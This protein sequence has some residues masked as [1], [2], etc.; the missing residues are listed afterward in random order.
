MEENT[1]WTGDVDTI[2]YDSSGEE[3]KIAA[4]I[5]TFRF[6][7]SSTDE[8]KSTVDTYAEVKYYATGILPENPGTIV[9]TKPSFFKAN[10]GV[11]FVDSN[12][13]NPVRPN[14][15]AQTF[16]VENYDGGVFTTGIDLYFNKKSNIIPVKVYLTNVDFD[17]PGKNIIPGTEK[18][19]SPFTFLK[20]FTNGNVNV[21]QGESITGSTSAASGPLAKIMDK[22]GVDLVPSSSGRYLLTNEQVYTM[23]LDNHNGRSFNQNECGKSKI[24]FEKLYGSNGY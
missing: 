16:K 8:D 19:I 13:D 1:T 12:T 17:K 23:V 21:T 4:G 18:V 3:I 15:L 22:K 7:S 5:K 11:Q 6:T 10:E 24:C 14:P 20:I 2:S 9:S